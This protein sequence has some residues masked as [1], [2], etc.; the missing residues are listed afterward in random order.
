MEEE[1]TGQTEDVPLFGSFGSTF[2]QNP[3]VRGRDGTVWGREGLNGK[4]P[5][6]WLD[7][8]SSRG[9]KIGLRGPKFGVHCVRL[10]IPLD[11]SG[12]QA[13]LVLRVCTSRKTSPRSTHALAWWG[14]SLSRT[15]SNAVAPVASSCYCRR[16]CAT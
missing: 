12:T 10:R 6:H 16:G 4:N 14:P 15:H 9:P 11:C 5:P 7:A 1:E 8:V 13:Q 3:I 2:E